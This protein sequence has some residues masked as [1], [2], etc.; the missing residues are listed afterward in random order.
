M[1][2]EMVNAVDLCQQVMDGVPTG[3]AVMTLVD[4][5]GVPHG[6]T[7]SSLTTVSADP[8]SVLMCIGGAASSRPF[9]VEG[10][11]FCA[12][13]LAS[14]QALQSADFAYGDE[15]PFEV[16][17][18]TPADDGTPILADT[19]AHLLCDVERVVDHHGVGVVLAAVVGGALDKDET[20]AY[21]NKTYY[22]G[23]VP[24]DDAANG[25]W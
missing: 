20:L 19:A 21:R 11:R 12:N 25:R 7:I 17:Q 10:Q 8:P 6:M 2:S 24:V 22:G 23:L 13:L 14:D 3:V 18:W 1:A 4:S 9:L 16:H 5:D 15:D